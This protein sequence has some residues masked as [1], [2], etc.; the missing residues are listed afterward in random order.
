MTDP[1]SHLPA[2]VVAADANSPLQPTEAQRQYMYIT[3]AMFALAPIVGGATALI[4][5][6]LAYIKRD[7]MAGTVYYDHMRFLIK[8]FW[9]TL[10]AGFI[11]AVLIFVLIGFLVLGLLTVWYIVRVVVGAVKLLDN[12]PV[13]PDGWFI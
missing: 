12:K 9:V 10:I 11:G 5:V 3:Y 13:T 6:I 2:S 4:G 1:H 7:D 8:T